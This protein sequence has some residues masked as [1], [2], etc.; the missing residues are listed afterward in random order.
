M[1]TDS[2]NKNNNKKNSAGS[3]AATQLK[4]IMSFSAAYSKT[5]HH[6]W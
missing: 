2:N 6:T 1:I 4:S 3:N 5:L